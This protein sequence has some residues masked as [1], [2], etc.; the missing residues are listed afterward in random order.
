MIFFKNNATPNG[1]VK[2][3]ALVL[4]LVGGCG[5][6]DR[7]VPWVGLWV[8]GWVVIVVVRSWWW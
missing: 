8:G 3:P 2:G 7:L 5:W 1:G 6:V 4:V